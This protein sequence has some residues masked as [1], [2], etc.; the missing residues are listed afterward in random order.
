MRTIVFYVLD[1][2]VHHVI[3]NI[4]IMF[5]F[6]HWYV[7]SRK[8]I[9]KT[10][11][12]I[13]CIPQEEYVHISSPNNHL[14]FVQLTLYC[15]TFSIRICTNADETLNLLLCD[16]KCL[17]HAYILTGLISLICLVFFGLVIFCISSDHYFTLKLCKIAGVEISLCTYV[18]GF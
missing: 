9:S 4:W 7:V 12:A 11:K 5:L 2:S 17:V 6:F 13:I 14:T 1:M 8:Y 15:S 18:S 3:H 10:S 16:L